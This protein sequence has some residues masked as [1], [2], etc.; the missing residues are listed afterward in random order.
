MWGELLKDLNPC[1]DPRTAQEKRTNKGKAVSLC[2]NI[3]SMMPTQT[4]RKKERVCSI[5]N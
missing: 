4:G 3:C 5:F 2:E 1:S